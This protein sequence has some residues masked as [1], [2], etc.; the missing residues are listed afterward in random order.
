MKKK[1]PY[2]ISCVQCPAYNLSPENIS[3]CLHLLKQLST[4][5]MIEIPEWC[6]LPDLKEGDKNGLRIYRLRD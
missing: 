2:I 5:E 1:I 4:E 6:P 3:R